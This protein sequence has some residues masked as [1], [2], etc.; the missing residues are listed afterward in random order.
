[1]RIYI[2]FCVLLHYHE[3]SLRHFVF[4]PLSAYC[5]ITATFCVLSFCVFLRIVALSR[6]ELRD[7]CTMH[8]SFQ[9]ISLIVNRQ[10]KCVWPKK[11]VLSVAIDTARDGISQSSTAILFLFK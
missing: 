8:Y 9:N 7:V 4:T 6:Q 5:R 11:T 10:A 1:M 2:T 3:R